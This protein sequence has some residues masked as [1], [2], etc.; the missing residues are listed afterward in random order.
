VIAH[1]V[2]HHVQKLTGTFQKME[3]VRGR[4]SQAVRTRLRCAWSCRPTA[5]RACGDT[6][7]AP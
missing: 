1:E 7:R 5:T 2:G 6:T 3:A 4:A